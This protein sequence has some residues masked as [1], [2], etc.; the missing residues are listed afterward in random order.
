MKHCTHCGA[1][2][3]IIQRWPHQCRSCLKYLSN[4][5]AAVVAVIMHTVEGR[6]LVR[7]GI[8]PHK[9]T[10]AFPGGYIDHQETW[11]EAA[12]REVKEETG[13]T[14]DSKD[15]FLAKVEGTPTN[16]L[17]FFVEYRRVIQRDEWL[18]HDLTR[19]IND[20]GE[21]EIFDIISAPLD[22][23]M[24]LGIPSHQRYWKTFVSS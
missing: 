22:M 9:G 14:I 8:E 15:L 13:V 21:Q 11:Q 23:K 16:F 4:G 17:V 24:A 19:C 3:P 1:I 5:P 18:Y 10:Y 12:I 7:R 2:L 6:L 20:K